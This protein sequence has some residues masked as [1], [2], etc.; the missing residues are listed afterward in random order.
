VVASLD[1]NQAARWVF[2]G[3]RAA[4]ANHRLRPVKG[5]MLDGENEIGINVC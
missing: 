5:W 4:K 2:E 3:R 1:R